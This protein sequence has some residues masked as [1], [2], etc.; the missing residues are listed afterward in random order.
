MESRRMYL[1][2]QQGVIRIVAIELVSILYKKE[3][4]WLDIRVKVFFRSE[5]ALTYTVLVT[6]TE[7]SISF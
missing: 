1:V 2:P 4:G 6:I 5:D 3:V 7:A